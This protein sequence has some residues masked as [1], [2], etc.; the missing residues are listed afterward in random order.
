MRVTLEIN[1][2]G[3]L[4]SP[5]GRVVGYVSEAPR[6]EALTR[7]TVR[8]VPCPACGAQPTEHCVKNDGTK[9]ISCHRERWNLAGRRIR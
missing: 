9:R 5:E 8:S 4:V 7:T 2:H 6:H 3:E 1:G